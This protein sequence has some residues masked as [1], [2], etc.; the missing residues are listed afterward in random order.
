MANANKLVDGA[1]RLVN[2]ALEGEDLMAPRV[3]KTSPYSQ[4]RCLVFVRFAQRTQAKRVYYSNWTDVA[5]K[6]CGFD[7][8]GMHLSA[9]KN[10]L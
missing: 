1:S 8:P 2:N 5:P 6:F 9:T 4:E 7:S 3:A 10:S